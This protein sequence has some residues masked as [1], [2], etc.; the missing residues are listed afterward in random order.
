MAYV[1]ADLVE[2]FWAV[3]SGISLSTQLLPHHDRLI[4]ISA[5]QTEG[6]YRINV[7]YR[8]EAQHSAPTAVGGV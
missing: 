8:A 2:A 4:S 6:I 1:G 7:R 3:L 5:T